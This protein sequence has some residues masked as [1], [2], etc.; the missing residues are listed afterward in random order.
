[1]KI[2]T[3]LALF[4]IPLVS[5]AGSNDGLLVSTQQG[6][7][8]GSL[9]SSTVRRF[10]GIPFASAGRWEAPQTPPR[11]NGVFQ[12]DKFGDSCLQFFPPN[13]REYVILTGQR[14]L[15]VTES[16]DC[17]SVNIWSPSVNRKQKTAVLMWVYGGHLDWGTSNLPL[18][19]GENIVRDQ[20]DITIVTFNY[21]LNIFGHPVA[22]QLINPAQS[23]N[24]CLLDVHA[25]VKWVFDN[26]A[27]FGGDPERITLF[28]QSAGAFAADGY[29]F[30]H[31]NDNMVKG[32][33]E[34]SG[35]MSGGP[36]FEVT[37]PPF[38]ATPWTTTAVA[39]GCGSDATPEQFACMK[40]TSARVLEETITNSNTIFGLHADGITFFPDITERVANG[41]F[42]RI[43]VLAGTTEN[44]R[45]IFLVAQQ[46]AFQGFVLPGITEMA[47]DAVA[48][49]MTC[50]AGTTVLGRTIFPD[51]STLP[52]LRAYH[53]SE[54]PLIF[55]T[56]TV[57][58]PNIAPTPE[59]LALSKYIQSAWVAFARDPVNGLIEFGWPL[60]DPSTPTLVQIGNRA[61]WLCINDRILPPRS[62]SSAI[63][64][65]VRNARQICQ[66][67]SDFSATFGIF[68]TRSDSTMGTFY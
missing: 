50:N 34:Q 23:Q 27:N 10:L 6:Q 45:D 54:I 52:S 68:R 32:L 47:S 8:Q 24:F 22:P 9:A 44:E 19:T 66:P 53:A 42:S 35:T 67:R 31:P 2:S 64:G 49:G 3:T 57:P 11:R 5:A 15:N 51:L 48:Q 4:L 7:V 25:A 30:A 36:T 13:N 29:A 62:D 14:G 60:Y 33:I 46:I 18:Y 17:L 21:R 55:G 56:V 16:E 59:E 28:G 63:L 39:V 43:P 58:F 20:D 1:M 65:F 26:I 37:D 38:N 61:N 12:A 40:S 41:N